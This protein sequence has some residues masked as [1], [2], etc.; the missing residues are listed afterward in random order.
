MSRANFN[1]EREGPDRCPSPLILQRDE[2]EPPIALEPVASL[3]IGL[4]VGEPGMPVLGPPEAPFD[5]ALIE[6]VEPR[7]SLS[8]LWSE[9]WP[10]ALGFVLFSAAKAAPVSASEP[11][12]ATVTARM[13]H[14]IIGYLVVMVKPL[15]QPPP[16]D[17]SGSPS[18]CSV[19]RRGR[20]FAARWQAPEPCTTFRALHLAFATIACAHIRRTQVKRFCP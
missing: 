13:V 9:E 20:T 11:A 17:C 15:K 7:V 12:T 8:V 1:S 6:P 10:G 3:P 18:L 14:L 16:D 5:P 4:S 19:A 2:P